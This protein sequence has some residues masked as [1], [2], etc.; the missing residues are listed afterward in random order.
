MSSNI[1]PIITNAI[2]ADIK[3]GPAQGNDS[4]RCRADAAFAS[5][6]LSSTEDI[7]ALIHDIKTNP[8]NWSKE[9]REFLRE[10][11]RGRMEN[12]RILLKDKE[13][14]SQ[15]QDTYNY[16]DIPET[17]EEIADLFL[18]HLELE[19]LLGKSERGNV[20]RVKLFIGVAGLPIFSTPEQLE[21]FIDL[22]YS[23]GFSR[24]S[25]K[26]IF[27][28]FMDEVESVSWRGEDYIPLAQ[29]ILKNRGLSEYKKLTALLE[30]KLDMTHPHEAAQIAAIYFMGA[31]SAVQAKPFYSLLTEKMDATKMD[32]ESLDDFYSELL[33]IQ[34][35]GPRMN[36]YLK[37]LVD[38]KKAD[39]ALALLRTID[40]DLEET[41]AAEPEIISDPPL[42]SIPNSKKTAILE[43]VLNPDNNSITAPVDKM[44]YTVDRIDLN[45]VRTPTLGPG[46]TFNRVR[47]DIIVERQMLKNLYEIVE[48]EDRAF[49]IAFFENNSIRAIQNV[50]QNG[51]SVDDIMEI[52]IRDLSYVLEKSKETGDRDLQLMTV[53]HLLNL[54]NYSMNSDFLLEDVRVEVV[55]RL[56]QDFL[57]YLEEIQL[58]DEYV[59]TII[60]H[61]ADAFSREN[62]SDLEIRT[63]YLLMSKL[64]KTFDVFNQ[65]AFAVNLY[66]RCV[67]QQNKVEPMMLLVSQA[68]ASF[69]TEENFQ[70]QDYVSFWDQ[71]N[72]FFDNYESFPRNVQLVIL[73]RFLFVG[74]ERSA[75]KLWNED[76]TNISISD[77]ELD[78]VHRNFNFVYEIFK[79]GAGEPWKALGRRPSIYHVDFWTEIARK[80]NFP[81][82]EFSWDV[83][84]DW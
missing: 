84:R 17:S 51:L 6:Y 43:E 3:T 61:L 76:F 66:H 52:T 24:G 77:K 72:F 69:L 38:N 11:L 19:L 13:L 65:H 31:G 8:G 29:A 32:S 28:S 35:V 15:L 18:A 1:V 30:D 25:I 20:E 44:L 81:V 45:K 14:G 58:E 82:E 21:S 73:S 23:S 47:V 55:G 16:I 42:P 59:A 53:K 62:A 56:K 7:R 36:H 22:I 83:E 80:Q 75:E 67:E 12:T 27:D 26:K 71:V 41:P 57:S 46:P 54:M 40:P 63:Y 64:L 10:F 74:M 34:E 70:Y 2:I 60:T 5:K 78:E 37:W 39:Y 68:A 48:E 49:V 79:D 33:S 4:E 9:D 50:I